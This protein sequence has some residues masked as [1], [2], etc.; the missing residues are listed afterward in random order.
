[1]DL[2]LFLTQV[3]NGFGNGV[4]Y[5]SLALALVL[6][7]RTT[8]LLNFAQGEMA[9]FATYIAWKLTDHGLNVWIA[10]LVSMALSFAF[11]A[12]L[13]R[14][15][16][17]FFESKPPLVL[18][19]V[20]IGLFL[21][22]NS[23]TQLFFGSATQHMPTAFGERVWDLGGVRVSAA[24]VGLAVVLVVECALLWLLLQRTRLG[25]ALRGVA[26]NPES[27]RLVGISSGSMLMFGWA[28]AAALGALAG[29]M[30]VSQSASATG[31]LDPS[32]MQR[33]LV[34]GFAAAAVGGFDSVLGAVVGGLLVGIS[35]SL[36]VEYIHPLHDIQLVVPFGLIV[37][38][39]MFRPS[40]LFG[41]RVVERV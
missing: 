27:S 41:Q 7:Y 9:L 24:V 23:V 31:A 28:I 16:I 6:I 14:T 39:L 30:A 2:R 5:A 11:G 15:V 17:R 22:F 1:M 33:L 3:F 34:F 4:V 32:L 35:Y 8:G 25:L 40:G 36:A 18:V 20:T 12:V 10:L 13:E 37:A 38:V 19:I 26:S 21:A 29:V